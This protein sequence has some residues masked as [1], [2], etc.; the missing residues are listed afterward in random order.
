MAT[1]PLRKPPKNPSD[2][3]ATAVSRSTSGYGPTG[4]GVASDTARELQ[5]TLAAEPEAP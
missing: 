3:R 1:P 2:R 4:S 5:H